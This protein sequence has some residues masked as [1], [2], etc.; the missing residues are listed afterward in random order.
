MTDQSASPGGGI[1]IAVADAGP[2]IHLDEL[3]CIELLAD[4]SEIRVPD[5]V[6]HEVQRHR[7]PV[8]RNTATALV[9]F[10]CNIGTLARAARVGGALRT[11]T[12][13]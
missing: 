13:G 9:R 8:L 11:P 5:A 2:L 4:F 6:W 7:Q 10:G 3:E 1:R 12:H